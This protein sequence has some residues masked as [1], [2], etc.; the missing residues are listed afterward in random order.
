MQLFE[1][2][3]EEK[4][5]NFTLTNFLLEENNKNFDLFPSLKVNQILY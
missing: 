1:S 5:M 3:G 2:R 4:L